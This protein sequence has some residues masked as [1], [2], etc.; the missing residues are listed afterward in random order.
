[1]VAGARRILR[2]HFA[3]R[4]LAPSRIAARQS[5]SAPPRTR[6]ALDDGRR[7]GGKAGTVVR[8]RSAGFG[9]GRAAGGG[10]ADDLAANR[11]QWSAREVP[12][13]AL[14]GSLLEELQVE[15][16]DYWSWH[17]TFHSPRLKKAQPLLGSTRVTDLAVN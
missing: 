3:P 9:A 6:L 13:S 1:M 4:A 14:A 7:L 2:L 5:P 11:E 8:A 15:P 17:C 10:V 16:D 12:D